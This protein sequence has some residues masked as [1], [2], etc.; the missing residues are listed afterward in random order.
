MD[1]L[2]INQRCPDVKQVELALELQQRQHLLRRKIPTKS[3]SGSSNRCSS[4]RLLGLR[5][6]LVEEEHRTL[7]RRSRLPNLLM[8]EFFA[9]SVVASSRRKRPNDTYL[10]VRASIKPN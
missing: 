6:R 4:G 7:I 8:T 10:I 5:S 1:C 2:I 3:P 9:N